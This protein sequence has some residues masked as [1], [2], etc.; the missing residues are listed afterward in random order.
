MSFFQ[1]VLSRTVLSINLPDPDFHSSYRALSLSVLYNLPVFEA[2]QAF[3]A[4]FLFWEKNRDIKKLSKY[5]RKCVKQI[6][7]QKTLQILN[8]IYMSY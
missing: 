7:Q 2:S 5:L 6:Y 8:I 3:I 4:F 1:N